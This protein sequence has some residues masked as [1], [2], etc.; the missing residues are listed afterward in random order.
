MEAETSL[1]SWIGGVGKQEATGKAVVIIEGRT[2]CCRSWLI[3]LCICWS[4]LAGFVIP[5]EDST[6]WTA[7]TAVD[8]ALER[9]LWM[10]G[11][12]DVIAGITDVM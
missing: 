5:F 10:E 12:T 6:D 11:T 4:T 9:S 8:T 3:S 7:S 1:R 2:V